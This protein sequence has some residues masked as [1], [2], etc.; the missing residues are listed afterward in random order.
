MMSPERQEVTCPPRSVPATQEISIERYI[1][2]QLIERPNL[3]MLGP[4][5]QSLTTDQLRAPFT[6]SKS[7]SDFFPTEREFVQGLIHRSAEHPAI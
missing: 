5:G 1:D 6:D 2:R 3:E 4:E 7:L